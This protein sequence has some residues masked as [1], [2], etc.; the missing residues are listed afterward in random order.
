MKKFY[1]SV[2][3]LAGLVFAPMALANDAN[4]NGYRGFVVDGTNKA[5]GPSASAMA[6]SYYPTNITIVNATVGD[7]F[8]SSPLSSAFHARQNFHITHPGNVNPVSVAINDAYGNPVFN[9]TVCRYA[10]IAAFGQ[11]GAYQ[12][13]YDDQLC[14]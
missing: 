10:V 1:F 4:T 8:I 7:L 11:P 14:Y 2:V 9:G 6:Y 13:L 3:A 12:Y 5:K